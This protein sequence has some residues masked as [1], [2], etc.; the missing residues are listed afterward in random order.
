MTA[1]IGE[2]TLTGQS[3]ESYTF[4]VYPSGTE[5]KKKGGVYYI[6]QRTIK[7]GGGA[8]HS[9]IYIGQT[10]D[11][12]ERFD[13]HHKADCFERNSINAISVLVESNK[14][15]RL[16]IESDLIAARNPPCND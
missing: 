4:N 15:E 12:S 1:K 16:D 10:K 5:F 13:E 3:G 2:L 6:S 9:V 7:S 8:S 14:Q 11:L